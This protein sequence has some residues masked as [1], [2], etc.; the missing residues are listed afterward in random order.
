MHVTRVGKKFGLTL[1][2]LM[3][4]LFLI[5]VLLS[6][7]EV[8]GQSQRGKQSLDGSELL[9]NSRSYSVVQSLLVAR[10][11]TPITLITSMKL[12]NGGMTQAV[13]IDCTSNTSNGQKIC[14]D[15]ATTLQSK[16]CAC[17]SIPNG[18]SCECPE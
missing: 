7:N 17:S 3:F 10:L 18:T 4:G 8:Y 1:K 6:G 14:L 15:A 12:S 11:R 9:R 13:V 16:G 5:G 2:H